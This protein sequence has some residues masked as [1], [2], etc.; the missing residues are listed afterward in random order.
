MR[1][2]WAK[3]R[4]MMSSRSG[5]ANELGEEMDAHLQFLAEEKMDRGMEPEEA[6]RVAHREFG[7]RSTLG[8][9]AYAAWQF[10]SLE[11]VLQD[12]RYGVR[13]ILRAPAFA[14]IVIFTLAVGVGANTA[15]FSA[16][17]TVLLSRCRFH[18]ASA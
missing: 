6:R 13:G 7:N 3:I 16:V 18:M 4:S 12:I 8:E 11:T 10:P 14:L 9:R 15:I 5:L 1:E 17:D 2:A